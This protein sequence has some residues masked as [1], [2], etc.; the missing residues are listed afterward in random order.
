M[1]IK[2]GCAT[3]RAI[4]ENDFDLLFFMM[5]DPDIEN[6]T[7]GWH[8]PVSSL[9]QKQWI[10]AYKNTDTNIRL[11]VELINGK[12]IG[13]VSLTDIDWKN[14]TAGLGYK[15]HAPLEDRIKGDI[16]DGS[17]ALLNYTFNELGLNCIECRTLVNNV[18][19]LKLQYKLGFKKEG[20]IRERIYK[21]GK[22]HNQIVTSLLKSE[23]EGN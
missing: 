21:N 9:E 3:L 5:N 1:Y 15:I 7:V 16:F 14:K 4:E 18:F 13:M 20:E 12:T 11:M 8:L 2:Y 17:M 19:S 6:Q 22:Y 10:A 23:F